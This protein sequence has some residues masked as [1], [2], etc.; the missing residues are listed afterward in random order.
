MSNR[1][2]RCSRKNRIAALEPGERDYFEAPQGWARL[3]RT[4]GGELIRLRPKRFQQQAII[5]VVY[6]T[7]AVIDLVMVTRLPDSE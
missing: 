4:I 2:R 5:G 1:E 6:E 3:M 7:R